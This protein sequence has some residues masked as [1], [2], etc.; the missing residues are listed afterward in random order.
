MLFPRQ[1]LCPLALSS[2]DWGGEHQ[3]YLASPQRRGGSEEDGKG[4]PAIFIHPARQRLADRASGPACPSRHGS[5]PT[6]K[7]EPGGVV[8]TYAEGCRPP[9]PPGRGLA[10]P[11]ADDLDALRQRAAASA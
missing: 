5:A 7:A 3:A 8:R 2:T 6:C 9:G 11:A 4:Y 10:Q 1:S